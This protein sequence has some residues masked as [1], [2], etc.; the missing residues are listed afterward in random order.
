MPSLA[1]A[2][3]LRFQSHLDKEI[4]PAEDGR[5]MSE[6]PFK[7][8]RESVSSLL[9][10]LETLLR[11]KG[12]VTS[13]E[14]CRLLLSAA[15]VPRSMAA[16]IL[17]SALSQDRRFE[18]LEEGFVRL[19]PA[20]PMPTD[21]LDQLDYTVIDL[22]TTGGSAADRV[23][24]VGAVR[25]E[26]MCVGREFSTLLDPGIPIPEFVGA[27]TGIRDDMVAGARRFE[28]IADELA[29]FVGDSIL[30]AHNLSFDWGFMNRELARHR[31]FVLANRRLCTVRI[32]RK[33]LAHLPDRRLDTVASHYG[34]S[35]E[36]RHRALGDARATA[37]ILVKYVRELADLRVLTL[38]ELEGYLAG[39]PAGEAGLSG[40]LPPLESSPSPASAGS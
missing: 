4:V 11:E 31:G 32:G 5:G 37:L 27:M 20:A 14:A 2:H 36:G 19:S 38:E 24:E 15:H 33:L 40:P 26:R 7:N 35:I 21:S 17:E 30:V 18:I 8:P 6:L 16:S 3:Y 39:K 29:A 9:A 22:E 34:I 23:I 10:S 25:V 28:E 12:R 13:E 1:A